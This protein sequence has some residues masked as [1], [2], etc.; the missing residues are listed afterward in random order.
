MTV[1]NPD[2]IRRADILLVHTKGS[3]ISKLIQEFTRS[4]WNHVALFI[5]KDEQWPKWVIEAIGGGVVGTP[6]E[7]KYIKVIRDDEGEI[8]E[9]KPSRKFEVAIVRV[10]N[11]TYDERR[12][13]SARAYHWAF[14]ERKYDYLLLFLG[15]VLHLLSFRKFYPK[16]LNSK[17]RF[18]CSELVAEAFYREAGVEFSKFTVGRYVTPADI[19]FSAERREDMELIQ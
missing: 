18:V 1:I 9:L 19:A 4:Y 17:N 6:F 11:L 5:S 15:M 13:V 10:K 7:L 2:K 16:W 3:F 14:E 12:R 8:L